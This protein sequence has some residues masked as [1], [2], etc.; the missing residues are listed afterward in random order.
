MDVSMGVAQD[1]SRVTA[2]EVLERLR[3]GEAIQFVDARS[4]D[5]WNGS[6]ET[7][8]GSIRIPADQAAAR[9]GELDQDR[10][11]ITWCT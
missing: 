5:A 9:A 8:A 7:I 3:R 11:V 10:A 2:D 1:V 6:D 4:E